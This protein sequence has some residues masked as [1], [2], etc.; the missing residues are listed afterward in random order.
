MYFR[1][2]G[3][4]MAV[5]ITQDGPPPNFFMEWMYNFISSGELNKDQLSKADV[6]DADLLD[7]IAKVF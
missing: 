3:E 4:I 6:T 2:V 7:L 1:T 5:S